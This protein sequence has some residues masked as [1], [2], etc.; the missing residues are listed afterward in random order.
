MKYAVIGWLL[1]SSGGCKDYSEDFARV[2]VVVSKPT[3]NPTTLEADGESQ[4]QIEVVFLKDV[5]PEKAVVELKTTAGL[6]KETGKDAISLTAAIEQKPDSSFHRAVRTQLINPAT[7][8]TVILTSR[9]V[10]YQRTD[11]ILFT[12]ALPDKV[13][14]ESDKLGLKSGADNAATITV[15]LL[16]NP[17]R[18]KP[19]PNLLVELSLKDA[20]GTSRGEVRPSQA[21]SGADGKCK[22]LISRGSDLYPGD[23]YIQAKVV[24][25]GLMSDSYKIISI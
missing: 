5:P 14:I 11:S 8:G 13:V 19:A 6:F 16:R 18:G 12:T 24:A 1:V 17:G 25:S 7:A 20:G 2:D 4:T 10:G 22:F 15:S 3:L 21:L 9:S 23:L